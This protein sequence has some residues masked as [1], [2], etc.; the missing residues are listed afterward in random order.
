MT[1]RRETR[2]T[3]EKEKKEMLPSQS[4]QDKY[5]SCKFSLGSR[6]KILHHHNVLLLLCRYV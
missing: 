2:E 6:E 5:H 1:E 4:F 3:R